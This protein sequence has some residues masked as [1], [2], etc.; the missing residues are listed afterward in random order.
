MRYYMDVQ[1]TQF[2]DKASFAAKPDFSFLCIYPW[3]RNQQHVMKF[4]LAKMF[5]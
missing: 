1:N 2:V 4:T 3:P 5:P